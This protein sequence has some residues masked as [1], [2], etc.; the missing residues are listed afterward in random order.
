MIAPL[1]EKSSQSNSDIS[2]IKVNVDEAQELASQYQVT[3]LPTV[4]AFKNGNLKNKFMG[5]KD[6]KFIENFIKVNIN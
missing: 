2:F 1:L 3:A 6:E 4:V 5:V